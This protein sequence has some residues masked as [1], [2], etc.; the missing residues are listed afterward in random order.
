MVGRVSL[1]PSSQAAG[2]SQ[3]ELFGPGRDEC[4]EV[5]C[6]SGKVAGGLAA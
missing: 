4:T 3:T 5:G 1:A 2:A 6:G